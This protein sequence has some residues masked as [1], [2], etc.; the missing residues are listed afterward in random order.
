MLNALRPYVFSYIYVCMLLFLFN[1][2]IYVSNRKTM[3]EREK[4]LNEFLQAIKKTL[5]F[6][7]IERARSHIVLHSSLVIEERIKN[8]GDR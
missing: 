3:R 5:Y 4:K 6:F 8:E 7:C 2:S 1:F